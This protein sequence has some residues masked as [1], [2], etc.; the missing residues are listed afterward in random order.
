[1]G[2]SLRVT[3]SVPG[4]CVLGLCEIDTSWGPQWQVKLWKLSA[5]LWKWR[6]HSAQLTFHGYL[7]KLLHQQ[8]ILKHSY[9]FSPIQLFVFLS[10]SHLF[11][12]S[13]DMC[14]NILFRGMV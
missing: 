13:I 8:V 10:I 11:Y 6:I 14:E 4:R 3:L 5:Y 1:M 2:T 12:H 7:V 9:L